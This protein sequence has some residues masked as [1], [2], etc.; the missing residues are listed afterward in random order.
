LA[1]QKLGKTKS[2]PAKAI[3]INNDWL[4]GQWQQNQSVVYQAVWEAVCAHVTVDVLKQSSALTSPSWAKE[5]A[6]MH[7][8][9][10]LGVGC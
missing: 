8:W 9:P 10:M 4:P 5:A 3:N 6:S 2:Q 1:A 7:G